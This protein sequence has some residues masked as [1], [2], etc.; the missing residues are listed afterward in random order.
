MSTHSDAETRTPVRSYSTEFP[1]DEAP[2]SENGMWLNGLSD[3]V[4][5]SDVEVKDGVAYGAYARN[6]EAEARAEQGNLETAEATGDYDDPTAMLTGDWGADQY[7]S[8]RVFIRNQ[9]EEY[10]QEARY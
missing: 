3:G 4:D 6:S 10:F 7:L 1:H 2:I 5:W 9:T 8:G